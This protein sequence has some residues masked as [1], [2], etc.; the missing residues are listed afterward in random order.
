[1]TQ[2]EILKAWLPDV[3]AKLNGDDTLLDVALERARLGILELRFPFGYAEDQELEPQYKGLQIDWAVE[4]IS[5]MG[6][7]GEVSHSENGTS[8]AYECGDVSNS[9][10]RRV[11]PMGKVVVLTEEE[12]TE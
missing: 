11:V 10:K 2:L 1:M 12:T 3:V 5:K 6:V 8:R 7:E 9:L 4:L